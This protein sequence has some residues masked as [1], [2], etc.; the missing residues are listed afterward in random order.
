MDIVVLPGKELLTMPGWGQGDLGTSGLQW[1]AVETFHCLW[2]LDLFF[3][4]GKL[5]PLFEG[6]GGSGAAAVPPTCVWLAGCGKSL[7]IV[8]CVW[9]PIPS[10]CVL[11]LLLGEAF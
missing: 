3:W 5:M 4:W 9:L 8:G 10:P 11:C 6:E 7:N 2:R 1:E